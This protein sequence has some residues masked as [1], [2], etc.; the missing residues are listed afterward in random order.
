MLL[1]TKQEEFYIQKNDSVLHIPVHPEC[2]NF[3]IFC[4]ESSRDQRREINSKYTPDIVKKILEDNIITTSKVNFSSGEPTLNKNLIQYIIW[5]K[6][7]GYTK[8]SLTTNGRRIKYRNYA[9]EL[10]EAGITEI[11]FSLHGHTPTL[12]DAMTRTKGSFLQIIEG[13]ENIKILQQFFSINIVLACVV[14]QKQMPVLEALLDFY[15]ALKPNEIVLNIVQPRDINM[16]KYFYRI[17]PK[18]SDVVSIIS[19]IYEKKPYLFFNKIN[20]KRYTSII[21]LPLCQSHSIQKTIGF[22][23][24]RIIDEINSNLKIQHIIFDNDTEKIKLKSCNECLYNNSCNGIFK[25]YINNYGEDE[26]QPIIK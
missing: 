1:Q 5:A 13:I 22:G 10:A 19:K 24:K 12:H 25:N 15:D 23:E 14:T 20:N 17:M 9:L 11:T 21:D 16:D 18:Y 7:L 26:F 4:F 6:E 2:N 8:I 3:C